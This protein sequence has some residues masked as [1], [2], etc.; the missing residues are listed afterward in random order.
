MKSETIKKL[1]PAAE[2]GQATVEFTLCFILFL[3]LIFL[4]VEGGRMI[5]YYDTVSHV[6]REGARFAIVRG[7]SSAS[8]A[9]QTDIANFVKARAVGVSVKTVDVC[10]KTAP[11]SACDNTPKGPGSIVQV[12]VISDFDPVAPII[13]QGII[14]LSSTTQM[15][16]SQ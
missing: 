11:T 10:W 5:F 9:S 13:P 8:P 16:I 12:K 6:A 3:L 15:V 2:A 7:S 14:T 1:K 4:I